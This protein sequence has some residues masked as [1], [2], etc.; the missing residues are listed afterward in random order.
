MTTIAQ[1][2]RSGLAVMKGTHFFECERYCIVQD[3]LHKEYPL[4]MSEN[5]SKRSYSSVIPH[6]PTVYTAL[7]HDSQYSVQLDQKVKHSCFQSPV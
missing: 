3:K 7:S 2:T 5:S 1:C 6:A 4:T